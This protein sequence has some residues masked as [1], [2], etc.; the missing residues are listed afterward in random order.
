MPAFAGAVFIESDAVNVS[1]VLLSR[2][3]RGGSLRLDPARSR[4]SI[5]R[6]TP[7]VRV[8]QRPRGK[9]VIRAGRVD[10]EIYS[11]EGQGGT[12]G[13]DGFCF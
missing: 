3:S 1:T 2:P 4:Q 11:V 8:Q 12:G 6:T 13:F 5:G 10:E 9:T 7:A